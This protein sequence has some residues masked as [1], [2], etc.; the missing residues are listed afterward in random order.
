MRRVVIGAMLLVLFGAAQADATFIIN[1][2]FEDTSSS[3]PVLRSTTLA[4]LGEGEWNVYS[5][6]PGWRNTSR[7]VADP[8]L[9]PEVVTAGIEIQTDHVLSSPAADHTFDNP[10]TGNDIWGHYVELDSHATSLGNYTNSTMTQD[11]MSADAGYYKFSFWF[12]GRTNS[13]SNND[14]GIS[15]FVDLSSESP[16]PSL[17]AD[18]SIINAP[19]AGMWEY[20]EFYKYLDSHTSYALSF[21]ADGNQNTLGGLLDDIS[22]TFDPNSGP[23]VPEPATLAIWSIFGAGAAGVGALRR[24]KQPGWTDRQRSAVYDVV[25]R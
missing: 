10:A 9:D 20:K 12:H 25:S 23:N 17:P 24:R 15:V 8:K 4:D 6:I 1:G 21:A 13:T 3:T 18:F 5:V 22:V 2:S 11:F 16:P 7:P 14:N 19:N